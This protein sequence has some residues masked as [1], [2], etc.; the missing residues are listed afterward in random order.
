M[1]L[2]R[3]VVRKVMG[4]SVIS[5]RPSPT[6]RRLIRRR[7]QKLLALL[8]RR[9][10]VKRLHVMG[11]PL[12]EDGEDKGN[13]GMDLDGGLDGDLS[14]RD[15]KRA[16]NGDV[17]MDEA[18][19]QTSDRGNVTHSNHTHLGFEV[20]LEAKIQAMADEILDKACDKAINWCCDQVLN[21]DDATPI[22]GFLEDATSE[23][24]MDLDTA[25][26]SVAHDKEETGAAMDMLHTAGPVG[27]DF[28]GANIGLEPAQ[29]A[30][31]LLFPDGPA[32]SGFGGLEDPIGLA[33]VVVG[34][35]VAPAAPIG[36]AP[37]LSVTKQS[38][39]QLITQEEKD[40]KQPG[41]TRSGQ[42]NVGDTAAKEAK[43]TI[44]QEAAMIKEVITGTPRSSPRLARVAD[45]HVLDRAKK[46]T[47]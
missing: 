27:E 34:A 44:L 3:R 28:G 22:D 12:W 32:A 25:S 6:Q 23:E 26:F 30:A 37:M 9:P 14:A 8:L 29:A 13:G 35:R 17:A 43:D 15:P 46:R 24:E 38:G 7:G 10:E 31:H 33:G 20:D 18:S 40:K 47:A 2:R 45:A 1:R 41:A 42:Q 4:G 11:R 16:R 5:R 19:G 39:L 21:E 36:V